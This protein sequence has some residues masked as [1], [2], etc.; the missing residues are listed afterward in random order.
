MMLTNR[1]SKYLPEGRS[2]PTSGAVPAGFVPVSASLLQEP[3]ALSTALQ[4]H[5]MA[6][7]AALAQAEERFLGI[8]RSLMN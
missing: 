3:A 6:Y 8:M 5:S 7:S 2:I 4:L 1:I